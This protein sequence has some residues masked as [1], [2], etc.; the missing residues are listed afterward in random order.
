MFQV[1]VT[2]LTDRAIL[3]LLVIS[4]TLRG[5]WLENAYK[6]LRCV[7]TTTRDANLWVGVSHLV[8]NDN[9]A[10]KMVNSDG[11][12]NVVD[13]VIRHNTEGN[14]LIRPSQQGMP[15]KQLQVY[16]TVPSEDHADVALPGQNHAPVLHLPLQSEVQHSQ[17]LPDKFVFPSQPFS[18]PG[19]ESHS[20]ITTSDSPHEYLGSQNLYTRV[21][22]MLD[23]LQLSDILPL[24]KSS[25]IKVSDSF[26][27]CFTN[28]SLDDLYNICGS[29]R[30]VF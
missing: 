15:S 25:F 23:A 21:T 16:S 28:H 9:C 26:L 30:T 22:S 6:T 10:T 18:P 29:D 14:E 1:E 2:I 12:S 19:I 17:T 5:S 8:A 11:K 20:A 13:A 7:H 27:P 4:R 3:V 24:L